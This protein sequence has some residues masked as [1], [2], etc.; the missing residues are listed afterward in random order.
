MQNPSL[1]TWRQLALLGAIAAI[2]SCAQQQDAFTQAD[3][4][5][6]GKLSKPEL[7]LVLLNAI[8]TAGDENG[9]SKI[10]FEEWTKVDPKADKAGFAL[11]DKDGDGAVTPAELK[12]YA[13]GKKSFDKLFKSIDTSKDGFVQQEEAKVFHE[14]LSQTEGK[15]DL[16]KLINY[17]QQ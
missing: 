11:R 16:E 6:D 10:T 13:D 7:G 1:Q 9:D 2:T 5:K 8:Y 14:K 4:D 17:S 12:A 3:K 15:T